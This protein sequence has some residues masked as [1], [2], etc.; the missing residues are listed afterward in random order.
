[1]EQGST[2]S[3]G[4]SGVDRDPDAPWRPGFD[5]WSEPD[6]VD[7]AA[8]R[9]LRSGVGDD[10]ESERWSREHGERVREPWV[11]VRP[12]RPDPVPVVPAGPPVATVDGQPPSSV[13]GELFLV[14]IGVLVAA[15]VAAAAAI[16][17]PAGDTAQAVTSAPAVPAAAEVAWTSSV[18]GTVDELAVGSGVVVVTTADVVRAFDLDDGTALWERELGDRTFDRV[19]VIDDRF[20]MQERAPGGR[21]VVRVVDAMTGDDVWDSFDLDGVDT[22]AGPPEEPLIVRRTRVDDATEM[23][24][25]DAESGVPVGDPVRLSPVTAA[26]ALF[27]VQPSDRRV[28]VWSPDDATVVAGPVDSFDLRTV[29]ALRGSVVALDLE[30]RI[31]VFDETGLRADEQ[32]FQSDAFG[33][34]TGRAE[35]AG[36][37]ESA[38]VGIIASGSSLGFSVDDARIETVW[39]RPGRVLAPVETEAG[40]RSVLVGPT[41]PSGE[42]RE[43]IIDPADGS[44]VAVTD[45]DGK[46]E[47]GP[48]LGHDGYVLAP[49]VGAAE[50]VVEA[51]DHDGSRRWSLTIPAGARYEILGGVLVIVERTADGASV[52]VAR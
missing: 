2:V 16:L 18:A 27:A 21:S 8:D 29:A 35:L 19:A 14:G 23:A 9:G 20:V 15:A 47:R 34:F 30:G 12:V 28:A 31:V 10:G 52:S 38:G 33:E 11:P 4:R 45:L 13:T 36:V 48:L 42:I 5:G 41:E 51:F 3:D 24:I 1:M 50:R 7:A 26:G 37:V 43:T 25:I 39:Q 22:I 17:L 44:T 6:A 46:R 32:P 40:P 49:A